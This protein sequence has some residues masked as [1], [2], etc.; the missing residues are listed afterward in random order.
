M[1]K[2]WIVVLVIV[3]LLIT[4]VIGWYMLQKA[5][6]VLHVPEPYQSSPLRPME[7]YT[8]LT[9][10][11]QK[12]P[13]SMKSFDP[14]LDLFRQH[15]IILLQECFDDT[16]DPLVTIF[17]E[18]NIY[19]GTLQGINLM[20]SGLAILS[21]FPIVEG[22]FVQF[23]NSNSMTFDVLSEKGF[24]SVI[25]NVDG[26]HVRVV[27]THLQSCDFERFDPSAML[28]LDE[29]LR[30]LSI[31]L[32]EKYY[33]IGGDFNIDATDLLEYYHKFP[34]LL[35]PTDPTIFI[36][37][38]TSHT[39]CTKKLGYDGLIF[40][41]FIASKSMLVSP[42]KVVECSYSDHNPVTSIFKLVG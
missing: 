2:K 26:K 10:N 41:Y 15:H 13:F 35:T 14:V 32:R 40:D 16:L 17:P 25:L 27:N 42:P 7:P 39:K 30:Y 9:Y 36:N 21:K 4:V 28:Q 12:F 33:I 6:K 18:F 22:E 11:I 38:T 31:R 24:L 37:F 8:I 20:N 34:Q 5:V 29:L 19:R 1:T 23:Q 3:G